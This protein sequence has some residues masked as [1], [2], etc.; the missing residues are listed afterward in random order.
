MEWNSLGLSKTYPSNFSCDNLFY[1]KYTCSK[2]G[3]LDF[4]QAYL[5]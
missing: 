1:D 2:A 3:L 4:V 5:S